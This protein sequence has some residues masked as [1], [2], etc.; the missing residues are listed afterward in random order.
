MATNLGEISLRPELPNRTRGPV[1]AVYLIAVLWALS[2]RFALACETTT[3][4][5]EATSAELRSTFQEKGLRVVTFIGYS[6]AEYED[7]TRMLRLADQVLDEFSP[8][9]T[10]INIGATAVGIGAVYEIAKRRGFQTIGIVS[11]QA[12]VDRVPLSP[13]VDRVFYIQ[14]QTWGG[15][16]P[17]TA[18]LSP[19]SLAM[20]EVSDAL[21]AIGGGEIGR[22]ELHG[23]L[24]RGKRVQF[25]PAD[26]N[27][28]IARERAR[29]RGLALPTD[30]R[31]AAASLFARNAEKQ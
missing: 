24:Q 28:A 17:G 27:H 9:N 18:L 12:K 4:T 13:C 10:V 7:P 1:R 30:F 16:L 22:D 11:A 20:V 3:A 26:M 14:D 21:F 31:G 25:F 29:T 23:A 6:G 8:A 5:A 2:A 19:T 15:F